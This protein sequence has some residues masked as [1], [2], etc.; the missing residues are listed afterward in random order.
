MTKL[1]FRTKVVK[2]NKKCVKVYTHIKM[3]N[4]NEEDTDL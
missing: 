4:Q 3:V 2:K 1:G